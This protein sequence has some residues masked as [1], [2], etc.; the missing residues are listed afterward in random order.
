MMMTEMQ[1]KICVVTGAT[2]GIGQA[3]AQALAAM[4]A[5][6]VLVGRNPS[7]GAETQTQIRFAT[8]SQTVD[9]IPS[10]LSSQASIRELAA[11]IDEKYPKLDVL[12]NNAGAVFAKREVSP[13]GI[14]MTFALDHLNYF[15]LTNL[16]LDKLKATPGARV[17]SVSS[18]AQTGMHINFKDLQGERFYVGYLAYG[19]AKLANVLFTYE[20]AQRLEGTGV[21]ANCLHPG[22]VATGFGH[23]RPGP[24]DIAFKLATPFLLSPEKGARTS[25]YLASSPEVAGVSGKYFARCKPRRSA[26]ASY[27][28]DTARRLWDVS[29]QMTGLA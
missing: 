6:V 12:L 5:H 1:G 19:Q 16:L 2:S 4:G 17:V 3:A 26:A 7:K 20:L 11:Q 9:F 28:R 24:L 23:N 25:V 8:G 22:V 29:L 18:T 13:D 14:E 21:T 15:L 10:D 27:N